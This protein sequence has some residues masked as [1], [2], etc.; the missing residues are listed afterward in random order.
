MTYLA[1]NNKLKVSYMYQN[2]KCI[3]VPFF[4]IIKKRA[5]HSE[6]CAKITTFNNKN[7]GCSFPC[8]CE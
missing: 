5:P 1:F 7:N 2:K 3:Y 8:P 4:K 6:K